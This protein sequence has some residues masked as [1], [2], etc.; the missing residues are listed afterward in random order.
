MMINSIFRMQVS[1]SIYMSKN[2]LRPFIE[3]TGF[4]WFSNIFVDLFLF[5]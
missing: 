2:E 4:D 3:A 5:W 1:D